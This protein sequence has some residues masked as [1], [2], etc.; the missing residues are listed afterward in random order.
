MPNVKTKSY[1]HLH[2]IVFVWGFTGVLGE[3][4]STTSVA[5]VW[6]R[7]SIALVF[8]FIYIKIKKIPI[9][10]S[11]NV[12]L[13]FL[14]SGF[15]IALHWFAFF[16]AIEVS[17]VSVT[18]ATLSTGAFFASILEPLF[19]RRRVIGYEV[20]F[21]LLVMCGLYIIY[22][23]NGNFLYG[24]TL[25]LIAAFL[26]ALFSVINSKFAKQYDAS[27]ISLYQILGGV[28]FLT[29][30]MF[31]T[32]ELNADF[33]V[34]SFNDWIYLFILGSICTAYT[35]VASIDVMKYLSPY[36]VMLTINLEPVYG[37]ILAI[38][39]FPETEKMSKEFYIGATI[40]LLTILANGYFKLR[41]K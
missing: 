8:V 24:I 12:L 21:G 32:G 25:A 41:R 38:L 28:L 39:I 33:F 4:I 26:S 16:E 23:V 14:G 6:Y 35:F 29:I 22:D 34:L 30:Y 1:L 31:F 19:Y 18:L 3:L 17:N 36:T 13:I 27:F 2:L 20:V 11:R 15:I 5:K 9:K 40:I 7:M 37:I 10:I